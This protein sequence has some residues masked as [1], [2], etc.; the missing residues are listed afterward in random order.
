MGKLAVNYHFPVAYPDAGFAN[1][2]YLLRIRANVFY[3]YTRA[4]DTFA[5]GQPFKANFRAAGTEVYF[6][7]SLWNELPF[8]FG[9]RYTRLQD[10]DLFGGNGPN[11]FELVVPISFF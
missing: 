10:P 9:L 11:R 6:D 2:F 7:S 8:T 3:D 5:N 1:F 4:T